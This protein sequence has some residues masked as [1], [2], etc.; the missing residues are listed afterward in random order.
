MAY[1]GLVWGLVI[2]GIVILVGV[3][4]WLIKRGPKE[5]EY[6]NYPICINCMAK[7][8]G[9]SGV[10]QIVD[11]IVSPE[12]LG[13]WLLPKDRDWLKRLRKKD[14]LEVKPE[15]IWV[16]YDNV[17]TFPAPTWSSEKDIVLILPPKS[18]Y[19]PSGFTN[20]PLGRAIAKEIEDNS[21]KKTAVEIIR[22]R[23]EV[24]DFFLGR[25]EGGNIFVEHE[26][27]SRTLEKDRREKGDKGESKFPGGE[28][29]FRNYP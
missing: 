15:L 7:F 6:Y 26:E 5:E 4:I 9:G 16:E 27:L 14:A 18:E 10:T 3:T 25:V 21:A 12:R 20:N 13:L 2:T 17:S 29:A 24:E 22:H 8:T 23:Q 28:P 11:K 1:A 19:L